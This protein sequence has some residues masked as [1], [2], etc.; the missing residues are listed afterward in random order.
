[1]VT[2]PTYSTHTLSGQGGLVV[3]F[4]PTPK[5]TSIHCELSREFPGS[6][7]AG[8]RQEME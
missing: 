4:T 3:H 7:Q 1:M 6:H 5:G 2:G 8:G